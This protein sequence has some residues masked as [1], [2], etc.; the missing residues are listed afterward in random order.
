MTSLPCSTPRETDS[1]MPIRTISSKSAFR[2]WGDLPG[3]QLCSGVG[4]IWRA[5]ESKDENSSQW[6][7]VFQ[8]HVKSVC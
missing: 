8:R 5:G 6:L 1:A 3:A 2:Q 7:I 4:E